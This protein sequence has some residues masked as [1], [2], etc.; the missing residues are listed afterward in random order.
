MEP[1]ALVALV[2]EAP[3]DLRRGVAVELERGRERRHGHA[4]RGLAVEL[5][6]EDLVRGAA[7]KVLDVKLDG[8]AASRMSVPALASAL[9]LDGDAAAK[10][11]RGLRDECD[12]CDRLHEIAREKRRRANRGYQ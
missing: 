12:K 11:V 7:D 6:V 10:I 5:D 9:K 3:D 4:A 8:K 1:V 2:A